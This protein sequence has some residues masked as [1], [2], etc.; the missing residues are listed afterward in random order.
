[1]KQ[2]YFNATLCLSVYAGRCDPTCCYISPLKAKNRLFHTQH[3][4]TKHPIMTD[5]EKIIFIKNSLIKQ[6]P[7]LDVGKIFNKILLISMPY[8][9]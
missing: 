1:M 7:F 8:I 4:E 2:V 9:V 3:T 5:I 6:K